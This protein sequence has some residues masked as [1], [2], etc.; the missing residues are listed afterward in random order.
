MATFS[1]DAY[2]THQ[3]HHGNKDRHNFN[4]KIVHSNKFSVT[5]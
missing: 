1:L 2:H 4:N 5:N 3:R